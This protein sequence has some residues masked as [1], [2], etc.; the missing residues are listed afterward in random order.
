MARSNRVRTS[1]FAAAQGAKGSILT[2]QLALD[3][4]NM[5]M[6]Y[7]DTINAESTI[8]LFEQI[9]RAYPEAIQITIICDNARYYLSKLVRVYLED[10]NIALMFLPPYVPNLNLIERYWKY[11]KKTSFMTA[12]TKPSR[13]LSRLARISSKIP[14]NICPHY[15]RY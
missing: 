15:A 10:S 4:M 8:K 12:I 5:V 13:N 14:R 6:R 9:Q 11:F 1:K 7:D 2:A 3:A